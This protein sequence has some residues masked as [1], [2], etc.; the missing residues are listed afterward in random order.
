M[1]YITS[2]PVTLG[3]TSTTIYTTTEDGMIA[4]IVVTNATSSNVTFSITLNIGG[5]DV[6]VIPTMTLLA[7]TSVVPKLDKIFLTSGDIV[8]GIASVVSSV[9]VIVSYAGVA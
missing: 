7:N 1:A 5:T 9:N 2:T 4:S 8:K 6:T 3:T